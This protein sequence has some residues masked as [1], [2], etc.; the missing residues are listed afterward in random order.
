[1]T[2]GKGS[3]GGKESK[4]REG[5]GEPVVALRQAVPLRAIAG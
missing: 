4:E 3:E 2:R 1:M 5:V